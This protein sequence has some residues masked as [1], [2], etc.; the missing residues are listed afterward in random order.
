MSHIRNSLLWKIADKEGGNASYLLGT[1]HMICIEDFEIKNKI[2]SALKKCTAYFMEV[3]LGSVN[4]MELLHS[5]EQDN[6]L[7]TD[8]LSEKQIAEL[9]ICLEKEFGLGLDEAK[10]LPPVALANKLAT[11]AMGCEEFKVAE[12][13]FLQLA[14]HMGLQ[15]GGLETAQEQ[16]DIAKKVFDGKELLTQ[17]KGASEYQELFEKM[18]SA[19]KKEDLK[20]LA[21]LITDKRF[22]TRSAYQIL[23][24][25]RNKKWARKIPKLISRQKSFIA[26]GAG[27]LPGEDGVIQLLRNQGYIINPVY[28]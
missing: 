17:L 23:V 27:H 28:R 24:T 19:Y 4:E 13:E 12:M 16:L 21:S 22:M 5:N 18:I 1:M 26:M 14:Q 7:I 8:G 9:K 25:R 2:L 11:K 3:D 6:K 10:N 15:T 20:T